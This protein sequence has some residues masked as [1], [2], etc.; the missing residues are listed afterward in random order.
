MAP[1]NE[2]TTHRLAAVLSADAVG[3]TRLMESAE[4]KTA[5]TMRSCLDIMSR[6]T[7]EYGGR[8]VDAV[9][10]NLLAEFT[11]A[12]DA[13]V[14]AVEI[15]RDLSAFNADLESEHRLSF[16]IGVN[17]GDLLVD[18]GQIT[19]SG[20]NVAARVQSL[21]TPGG[22]ALS[23]TAYDQV[24]GRVA[25][26]FESLGPQ[27]IKNF[28]RPI[29]VY[30]VRD[31]NTAPVVSIPELDRAS[32]V[33]LPFENLTMERDDYLSDGLTEELTALLARVP[34]F[35]VIARTTSFQYKGRSVEVRGLRRELGVRY[36][37][38]GSLR[39]SG[40]KVRATAQLVETE[41]GAHL[42]SES[43]TRAIDDVFELHEEIAN[44]ITAQLVPPLIKAE[45]ERARRLSPASLDAWALYQAAT[46]RYFFRGLA[47]PPVSEITELLDRAIALDPDYAYALGLRGNM[48]AV[49]VAFGW[50]EDPAEDSATGLEDA[51]MAFNLAGDDPTVLQYWGLTAFHLYDPEIGIATLQRCLTLDPNNAHARANLGHFLGRQG[52]GATGERE[53]KR[54][55][56]LSPRDPRM[57]AWFF[58]LGITQVAQANW[59]RAF[60]SV[61]QSIE[62]FDESSVVWIA[63]TA[64]A[65][66]CDEGGEA[67]RGVSRARELDPTLSLKGAEE[68]MRRVVSTDEE[69]LGE[70]VSS[71]RDAGLS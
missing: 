44:K 67:T 49:Q 40:D 61:R 69:L 60:D 18:R 70:L 55:M 58:L 25:L 17:V 71:L 59:G 43:Y 1:D 33:V 26:T 35:L 13:V 54:A 28:P 39:V 62:H 48:R 41:G 22:V 53:I 65:R 38:E 15:Q 37:I 68:I 10:D 8:V 36:A 57:G 2:K 52:R 7:V 12:I 46:A 19:G 30:L 34:G 21:A 66:R 14:C 47:P 5:A 9:G 42:W 63:L 24:Q 45:A 29:S 23:G 32:I 27:Q 64:I 11:S 56:E 4:V 16:R 6:R 3:Y 50:S 31:T 20:I 51:R